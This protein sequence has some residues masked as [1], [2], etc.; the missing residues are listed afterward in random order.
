MAPW[1]GL[2]K[3]LPPPTGRWRLEL[4]RYL[5][6][7]HR[8]GRIGIAERRLRTTPVALAVNFSRHAGCSVRPIPSESPGALLAQAEP[9][10]QDIGVRDP[11]RAVVAEV[12]LGDDDPH[13]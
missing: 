6:L 10:D 13:R 9:A 5:W 12:L 3:A 4:G 11:L 1:P 8:L 7:R 2:R